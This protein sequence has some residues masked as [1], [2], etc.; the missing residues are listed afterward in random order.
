LEEDY[1]SK[2]K[3]TEITMDT[4]YKNNS[5]NDINK[6]Y[7]DN[8][9]KQESNLTTTD[10]SKSDINI[11]EFDSYISSITN[12]DNNHNKFNKKEEIENYYNDNYYINNNNI[13]EIMNKLNCL[14][15]LKCMSNQE[16]LLINMDSFFKL[17]AK[18]MN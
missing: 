13:K 4:T 16:G 10:E 6:Y 12:Y 8:D 15:R 7:N 1:F 5:N 3:Q 18:Y 11:V 2:N 17:S 14:K 9:N